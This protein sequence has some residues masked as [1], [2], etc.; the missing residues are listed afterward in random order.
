MFRQY[1]SLTL[2]TLL[3]F[4]MAAV[5]GCTTGEKEAGQ[6]TV[7]EKFNGE[8]IGIEPGAGIMKA[9]EKAIKEYSLDYT[10]KDSSSAAMVAALKS[11]IESK[12]WIVVTGWTP[13]WMFARWDLKY[14]EDPKGVY[15]GEEHIATIARKG[16]QKDAPAAYQMLDAFYWQPS[17]MEAVMLDINVNK[18]DPDEAAQKWIRENEDKV[19]KWIPEGVPKGNL[20]KIKLGY[21]EWDSEIASTHV[22]K[23]VLMKLGYDVELKAV[24]AG[25]MWT[26]IG[27]GHFDAIV[28]AWLPHTHGDYYK[29]VKDK[30]DNLGPNLE[31]AKIGLVVPDY[32]TINSIEDLNK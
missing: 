3:V 25:V 12:K 24:D 22:V 19:K 27:A 28:A 5:F 18:M 7:K 9:T 31:G 4:L 15:G 13:H 26:G 17:D 16:L 30:V 11:A 2:A 32:V 14:L 23:H 20:K 6:G 1:R 29:Q 21:V 8:I 10:L